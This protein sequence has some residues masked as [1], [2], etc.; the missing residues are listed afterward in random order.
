MGKVT[1]Y[2]NKLEQ[3]QLYPI[4]GGKGK[5]ERKRERKTIF[6]PTVIL[7]IPFNECAWI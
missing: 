1:S 3:N 7:T 5:E 6:K 4:E 2:M